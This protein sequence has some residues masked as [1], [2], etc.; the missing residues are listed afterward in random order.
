MSATV[1]IMRGSA[2]IAVLLPLVSACFSPSDETPIGDTDEATFGTTDGTGDDMTVSDSISTQPT[3]DETN[4][5]PT[6]VDD[7]TSPSTDP[8]TTTANTEL[9]PQLVMS[10]PASGDDNAPL[11]GYF[12]LYFDR[13]VSLDDAVGHILVSQGGSEPQPISPM[14]CP[15]DA[16]PTCIAGIFPEEFVDP[17]QNTLPGATAHTVTVE[18]EFP[19]PDGFTNT[20]DQ[21]VEFTTFAYE[22]NFFDDSDAIVQEFGG[23]AYDDGSESLFLV[24][25]GV[26]FGTDPCVVRRIPIPGGVPGTAS[27]A[28][29]PT[30][31]YLCYGIDRIG[32]DLF[33]S[34]S[35]TDNV[36][37]YSNLGAASLMATESVIANPTLPP[38]LADL[39]EGWHVA[40]GGNSTFF[41][42]GEFLGGI[43]DSSILQVSDAGVWSEFEDGDNLWD[44]QNGVVIE[45]A[46]IDGE[47]YLFVAA[48]AGIWKFRVADGTIVSEVEFELDYATDLRIDS[49]SRLWVGTQDGITVLE[50]VDDSYAELARRPGLDTTRFALREDGDTVHVYYQRFREIGQIGHLSIDF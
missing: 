13:V 14:A 27:T 40:R 49:Q 20:M 21:I 39:S 35:Y 37:R 23:I 6:S 19:D 43:E 25:V 28:A 4:T 7:T 26:D 41:S 44:G 1:A 24:G 33:V 15:P 22:P 48:E 50:V 31:S 34:G 2:S 16:D 45:G 10:V 12:L 36:F 17:E 46:S 3:D 11:Q 32:N 8:D 9:G 30:G 47:D 38:P 5:M 42:H 18:A 29:L